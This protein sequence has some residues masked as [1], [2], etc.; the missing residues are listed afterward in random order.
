MH[1]STFISTFA[2]VIWKYV[3]C[4]LCS[5]FSDPEVCIGMLKKLDHIM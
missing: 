1:L 2:N 5:L 3:I 4:F